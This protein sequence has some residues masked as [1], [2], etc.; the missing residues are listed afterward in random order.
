MFTKVVGG[1]ITTLT[2]IYI[3]ICV[4]VRARACVYCLWNVVPLEIFLLFLNI[5]KRKIEINIYK[6]SPLFYYSYLLKVPRSASL[7][8]LELD[9]NKN[10][11]K[12]SSFKHQYKNKT[13]TRETYKQTLCYCIQAE[14]NSSSRRRLI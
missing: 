6:L 13:S 9:N 8:S 2:L 7:P 4:C 10:I 11:E 5:I 14:A 12:K 1:N 3:Y